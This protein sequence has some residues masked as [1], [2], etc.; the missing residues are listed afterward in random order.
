MAK[1]I[2]QARGIPSDLQPGSGGVFEVFAGDRLIFSKKAENRF[3]E[4]EEILNK[5]DPL[6]ANNNRGEPR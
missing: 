2:E 4:T 6:I 1:Q 5:L 3:P